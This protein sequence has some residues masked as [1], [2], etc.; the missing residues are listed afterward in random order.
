[1]IE[2][3]FIYE[4]FYKQAHFVKKEDIATDYFQTHKCKNNVANISRYFLNPAIDVW[5]E[6]YIES[7]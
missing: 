1:M 6:I 3:V 4:L 7:L 2:E 5:L